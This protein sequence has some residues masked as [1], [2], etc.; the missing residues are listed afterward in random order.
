MSRWALDRLTASPGVCQPFE[1][2]FFAKGA[3]REA[4]RSTAR[5]LLKGVGLFGK[6]TR[7]EHHR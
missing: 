3:S 5:V 6:E 2:G 1:L 7:N 4:N